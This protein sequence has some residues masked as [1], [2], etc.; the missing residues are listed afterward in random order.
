MGH[1][2]HDC[3]CP[4]GCECDGVKNE[5]RTT[6]FDKLTDREREVATMLC[7]GLRN[8]EIAD[9]LGVSVKTIDTHRHRVLKKLGVDNN[10]RLVRL[11]IR[12]GWITP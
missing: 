8:A 10:V 12:E 7:D 9:R 2:C 6:A 1:G 11:A 4:N 5:S 3:G